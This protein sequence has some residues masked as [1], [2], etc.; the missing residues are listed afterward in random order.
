MKIYS[1]KELSTMTNGQL[2]AIQEECNAIIKKFKS[3][4]DDADDW[5]HFYKVCERYDSKMDAA[6]TQE[7]CHEIY[8]KYLWRLQVQALDAL[9]HY[10]LTINF[11]DVAKLLK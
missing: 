8:L 11:L 3:Y 6:K 9:A 7:E 4:L 1:D 5:E 2:F 10:L